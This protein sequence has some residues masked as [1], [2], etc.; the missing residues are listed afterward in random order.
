VPVVNEATL[1]FQLGGAGNVAVNLASLGAYVFLCGVIGNDVEGDIVLNSLKDKGI[2]VD[3]IMVVRD[4]PTTLKERILVDSQQVVRIDREVTMPVGKKD[5][6]AIIDFVHSSESDS[7]V[8][9]DYEKGMISSKLLKSIFPSKKMVFVDP[10]R[11]VKEY[12][13]NITVLFPNLK[14]VERLLSRKL[15][16]VNSC[17]D[18][19]PLNGDVCKNKCDKYKERRKAAIDLQK[20]YKCGAVVIKSGND[21]LFLLC[22]E[23]NFY[24]CKAKNVTNP[25]VIGAGDTVISTFSFLASQGISFKSATQLANISGYLSVEKLGTNSLTFDEIC[26]EWLKKYEA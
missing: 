8:I 15:G 21:G 13:K 18:C 9:S 14:E 20:K 1:R 24:H 2:N 7:I 10:K 22:G 16:S 5:L 19:T 3:G 12:K 17:N 23:G 6:N 11:D 4:R 25:S 26:E